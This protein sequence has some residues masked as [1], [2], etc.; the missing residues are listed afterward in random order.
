MQQWL[1]YKPALGSEAGTETWSHNSTNLF[2]GRCY[3]FA[4]V[5][6]AISE[7]GGKSGA[8]SNTIT[9]TNVV[10]SDV[11]RLAV[12]FVCISNDLA[13]S[14]Y[15]GET[16]GNWTTVGTYLTTLGADGAMG[17]QSADMPTAGTITGGT[18]GLASGLDAWISR[19]FALLPVGA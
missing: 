15:N 12:S 14:D 5:D 7:S 2:M 3:A 13:M 19:S 1:Y 8:A 9:H 6:G 4:D 18:I 17:L 10:T 11:N 16:G